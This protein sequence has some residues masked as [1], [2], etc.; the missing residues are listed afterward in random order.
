[1]A[2]SIPSDRRIHAHIAVGRPDGQ[3][4]VDLTDHVVRLSINLGDLSGLGTGASG[5]D[6]VVRQMDI[7][8]FNGGGVLTPRNKLSELNQFAG[9]YA[10]LL[11]PN[12]EIIVRVAIDGKGEV[13]TTTILG[14]HVGVGDG[15]RREFNVVHGLLLPGSI[16]VSI[17]G[18]EQQSGYTVDYEVGRIIFDAPPAMGAVITADYAYWLT[19]FHGYLGDSISADTERQTISCLCRD[20]SKRLQD[21]YIE[22]VREYGSADGTPAEEVIQQIIDD[23]L[24]EGIVTVYCPNPPGFMVRTYQ[25]EYQSVWDAVQDVA[26]QI[27]WFLG[28]VWVPEKSEYLLVLREPGRDKDIS[29]ADFALNHVDD[30]YVQDLEIQDSSVRNAITVI[31]RNALTGERSQVHVEDQESI[32]EYGRRAMQIEEGDTELIKDEVSALRFAQAAL[33]DL[34]DLTSTT[35]IEMPLFPQMDV[36][37][38]IKY[39][40]PRLSSEEWE[41]CGVESVAHTLDWDGG[42]FRTEVVGTGRVVGAKTRWMD[43]ETRPGAGQP[44]SYNRL[45]TLR[46]P[47]PPTDFA[48]G[49]DGGKLVFSWTGVASEPVT[50]EIRRGDDWEWAQVVAQ[51]IVTDRYETVPIRGTSTYLLKS[52]NMSGNYSDVA[53]RASITVTE[54][55]LSNVVVEHDEFE[56]LGG[57]H[58]G[59]VQ[60]ENAVALPHRYRFR[61]LNMTWVDATAIKWE[62]PV[63]DRGYYE[64]STIDLGKVMNASISL[65]AGGTRF[66]GTARRIYA[67][68]STDGV[69]YSD[70]TPIVDGAQR[71]FRCVRFKVE[72]VSSELPNKLTSFHV[73]IDVP[74]MFQ[75]G[76][77]VAVP[78]EGATILFSP[79]YA[80]TPA[81]TVTLVGLTG[82]PK[83]LQQDEDGFTVQIFDDG[84]AVPGVINWVAVGY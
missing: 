63:V 21:T 60:I 56:Q 80:K 37:A 47:P 67:S 66:V 2:T 8:F 74:D 48:V 24:G 61:D 29:T 42:R 54:V 1:M 68:Y 83:V 33:Y 82:T 16:A 55:P 20:L 65:Q 9:H 53:L 44:L 52:R 11:W 25:V 75:R 76:M 57:T 45:A 31:Y 18:I 64:T 71:L 58:C 69:E 27:G 84:T 81:I 22:Q 19:L 32:A 79:K 43:M 62:S 50:Y 51:G 12:R 7:D 46:K 23:N 4:W 70:W 38:G 35:R 34:K 72:L 10:P 6:G 73:T 59:T 40:N 13:G 15:M 5:V 17:D 30:F 26:R 39:A 14:E 28:Y 78:A 41:F 3:T 77:E 49:Q 36:F